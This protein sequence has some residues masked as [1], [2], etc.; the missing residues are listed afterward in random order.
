MEVAIG[1]YAQTR[2]G[3][4]IRYEI[5][6]QGEPL[7]LIMGFS[8]SGRCW[9]EPF[10]QAMERNFRV[11]VVDNR[12]TGE[13]DKPDR[14]WTLG[15]M[16]ADIVAVLDHAKIARAHIYGISMGGM[17]AQ[18]LA[19]AYPERVRGLVL[20]CTNCGGTHCVQALPEVLA[21]L[22][23]LPGAPPEEQ[24]RRAFSA[25]CGKA[26]LDSERGRQV[27]DRAIAD[28]GKYPMT[29]AHIFARQSAAIRGFDTY[30]RLS[31]IKSPTL[32]IH[33]DNDAIVPYRNAR[34]LA[35]GIPGSRVHTIKDVGHMFFWEAPLEAAHVA[36]EFFKT[37]R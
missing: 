26:F 13:S 17:I 35:Q 16:A 5:R 21:N 9:G 4:R 19:L 25:A 8:G 3:L 36:T 22:M 34:I 15:D 23:P 20:G 24:T 11:V 33:G 18:E 1:D 31:E 12:G 37:I 27:L 2:D 30:A 14:P 6:G 29:P 7:A 32:I 10:L 28:M